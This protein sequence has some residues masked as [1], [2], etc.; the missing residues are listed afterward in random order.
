MM[1]MPP[2]TDATAGPAGIRE[3]HSATPAAS[4]PV[5]WV[6]ALRPGETT[7]TDSRCGSAAWIP[8]AI[9]VTRRRNTSDP[10]REATS[11]PRS[12]GRSSGMGARSSSAARAASSAPRAMMT[13]GSDKFAGM[14]R[15]ALSGIAKQ[16]SSKYTQDGAMVG[17]STVNPNSVASSAVSGRRTA[18]PSAPMS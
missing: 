5:A 2:A 1:N 12:R 9:G 11:V 14:P 13:A 8:P 7:S 10:I 6:A 16:A 18:H 4:D 15:M 17:F 3:R